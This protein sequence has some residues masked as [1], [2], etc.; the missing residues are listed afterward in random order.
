[1]PVIFPIGGGKG[2][3]G[4]SFI[5]ANLGALMAKRGHRVILIDL[6]LGGSNLHTLLG[7]KTPQGGIDRFLDKTENRLESVA[8][9]THVPN[10]SFISS[11]HCSM[12]IANL[13]HAQKIKLI[14]AIQKLACDCI[15][16]DLGAGTHFNTV[17]FFL[18]SDRGLFVC[19]PEPTSIENAFRFIKAAYLRKLKQIISRNAFHKMVKDTVQDTG[20]LGLRYN[21]IID[22]VLKYDPGMEMFL[23]DSI[24][25]FE[26]KFIL[27]QFR[28][29]TDSA[30]GEKIKNVCNRHFYSPFEYLG[31]I[32]YDDRVTDS[33]LSKNLFSL[34]FPESKTAIDFRAIVD[35]L[36]PKR[37]AS[38]TLAKVP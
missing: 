1:M 19:T 37:V 24:R 3:V 29:N 2:G 9:P 21:D 23:R 25:R 26:F 16:L 6:D 17:D 32:D 35:R 11:L 7:I 13:Y 12:E 5:S 38:H 15:L 28:K 4:K 34:Q 30:L 22:M 31:R 8:V 33:I 18:A 14:N 20:N 27:N 36:A 10:L